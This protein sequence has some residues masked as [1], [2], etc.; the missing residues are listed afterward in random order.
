MADLRPYQAAAVEAIRGHWH[1]NARRVLCVLP[2]GGGKTLLSVEAVKGRS[3][4]WV[5]HTRELARQAT[6]ALGGAV[7]QLFPGGLVTPG[8][9]VTVATIQT[10][11]S[12]DVPVADVLVVD[13]A[14]LFAASEWRALIER[15]P[16]LILG[17][18][19][20]PARSDDRALGDLFDEI[21][22]AAS[23]SE[24][25]RAGHIVPARVIRPREVVKG[26]L[27]L[28]PVKAWERYGEGRQ[29][30]VFSSS[31]AEAKRVAASFG[32]QAATIVEDTDT[33]SRD[34]V[35]ESLRS[36]ALR[37]VCSVNALTAGVDV[38]AVSCVILARPFKHVTPY[39]QACGRALR[40]APGKTHAVVIDLTGCSVEH[41][42][43]HQDRTFSLSGKGVTGERMALRVCLSCGSTCESRSIACQWCG[44]RR[45]PGNGKKPPKTLDLDLVEAWDHEW[46]ADAVK[47]DHLLRLRARA[48]AE[49]RTIKWVKAQ[50][51]E[52]FGS[53]PE[54]ELTRREAEALWADLKN[55][56][57]RARLPH[58]M[59]YSAFRKE[60]GHDIKFYLDDHNR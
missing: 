16:G 44:E 59:P 27:A 52:A 23:Y 49:N 33:D 34:T 50:Y 31:I 25:L 58:A 13:E 48:T 8:A 15:W 10:L 24:L 1:N 56:Q 7:T 5:T 53:S 22:V 18:T 19:A 30:F 37:V 51:T 35:F 17:L 47:A 40:A 55:L 21:I 42:F 4:L 38:P 54:F 57:K 20:T 6:T 60:T 32:S 11:L 14:H 9:T 36:G 43:P 12:R 26:G 45:L 39:M 28:D 29:T 2:T 46:T 41:G 3:V